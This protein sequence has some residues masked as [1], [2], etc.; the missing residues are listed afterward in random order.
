[1]LDTTSFKTFLSPSSE[2]LFLPTE[3]EVAAAVVITEAITQLD[4]I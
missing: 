4:S 1:M 2:K 3:E